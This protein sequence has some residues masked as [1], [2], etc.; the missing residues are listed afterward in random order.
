MTR[1]HLCLHVLSMKVRFNQALDPYLLS[2]YYTSELLVLSLLLG[3]QALL[4]GGQALLLG[5]QAL[6]L[7]GQA[8]LLGGPA[9]SI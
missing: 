8:L 4:L 5:G 7:G 9:C 6:L 1:G 3:G 2:F